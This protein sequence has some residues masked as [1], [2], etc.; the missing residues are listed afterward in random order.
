MRRHVCL[1]RLVSVCAV[2]LV[3][4]LAAAQVGIEP[5]RAGVVGFAVAAGPDFVASPGFVDDSSG[6]GDGVANPGEGVRVTFSLRNSGL[7][8]T[9]DVRVVVVSDDPRV[10]VGSVGGGAFFWPVGDVWMYSVSMPISV[11]A[12]SGD[13]ISVVTVTAADGGPW[14]FILT[15]PIVAPSVR[16]VGED[17]TFSDPAPTGDGD[18]LADPGERLQ[19]SLRLRNDGT[20]TAANA[21]VTLAT[22]DAG[23]TVVLGTATHSSWPAGE[24]RSLDFV[25][26]V[27]GAFTGSD[28]L[29]FFT[30]VA[31]GVVPAQFSHAI[32][33]AGQEPNFAL[34]NAWIYDPVPGGNRDGRAAPGERV[35]PRVRLKT[36]GTGDARNV[37]VTMA[38]VDPDITVVAD[39]VIHSEWPAGQARN[40]GGL[41]FDVSPGATP[42]DF[43]ATVTVTADGAGPWQFDI[44]FT[45]VEPDVSFVLESSWVFDPEPGGNSD[46]RAAPGERVL[47]RRADEERWGRRRAE[48]RGGHGRRRHRH[49]DRWRPCYTRWWY[50]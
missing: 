35:L 45:I 19:V 1:V 20:E 27:D 39:R 24:A 9:Q 3:P 42:H 49:Q 46:G 43:T 21:R 40:N 17:T 18:G 44:P 48:R 36:T 8:A 15:F 13:V 2:M 38:V 30:V 37:V 22:L 41:A 6:N 32:A 14:H 26:D 23:V 28:L 16:F 34:R 50:S 33:I 47:P 31:D 11:S 5:Q 10:D 7:S 29:L 12:T 4:F 25:V